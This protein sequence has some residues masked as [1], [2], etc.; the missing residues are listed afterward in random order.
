MLAM[1]CIGLSLHSWLSTGRIEIDKTFHRR[2]SKER[3]GGKSLATRENQS[4]AP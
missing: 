2:F 4:V 1:G 3:D